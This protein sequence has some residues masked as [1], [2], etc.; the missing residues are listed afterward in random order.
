MAKKNLALGRGLG[1]ILSEVGQA[2]ENNFSDN[3]ELVVEL[4][5]DNIKPNPYQPRKHFS[6]DSVSEL[7]QSISEHGLLQPILVYEDENNDYVLIAGERRLR[8]TK[9]ASIKTI[10]A[11]IVEMDLTKLREIALIENI[12]REDLNIID[13]ANSYRELI[14]DY[15]ITHEELAKRIK[16]SRTQ[17]TNTLRILNL[18]T[19]IQ[20]M[21]IEEKISQGHAKILVALEQK[22]QKIVLDSIVGQKLSVRDTES[23]VK[24]L[25]DSN[26]SKG[27]IESFA[28][29]NKSPKTVLNSD[30]KIGELVS[31]LKKYLISASIKNNHLIL[32]ISD[33]SKI[34][35]VIKKLS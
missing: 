3:S 18:S 21:L 4:D 34:S 31:L 25:K 26:E 27:K 32:D 28:D 2:Y 23:L 13:L 12:Q 16:K 29:R 30:P 17:I 33:R 10:K 22:E 15:Q 20:E 19:E 7:S 9:L 11:I 8:A 1:A 14:D 35:E 6:D 24:K 5:V